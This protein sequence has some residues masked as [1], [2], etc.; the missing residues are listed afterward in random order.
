MSFPVDAL[1]LAANRDLL[2]FVELVFATLEPGTVFKQNW[3]YE[4]ICW[5]LLRVMRGDVRRLIINVPP[6]SGKSV[7]TSVAWPPYS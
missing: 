1:W 7:I 4:H 2:T 3:H 6:R 5:V